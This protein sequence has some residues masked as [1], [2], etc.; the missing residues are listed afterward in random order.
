[1]AGTPSEPPVDVDLLAVKE[2]VEEWTG[3]HCD[4]V[5][6]LDVRERHSVLI[7]E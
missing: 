6:M 1:M 2:F 5:R 3:E 7:W 4:G